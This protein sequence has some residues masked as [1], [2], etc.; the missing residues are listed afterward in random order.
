MSSYSWICPLHP[1]LF[2]IILFDNFLCN[3]CNSVSA[4]VDGKPFE[5]LP[6]CDL[7]QLGSLQL[8]LF[9]TGRAA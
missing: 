9:L 1:L 3:K 7:E 8:E 2:T 6:L 5:R 4:V